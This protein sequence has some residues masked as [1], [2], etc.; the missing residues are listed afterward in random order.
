M[1]W[2]ASAVAL[3]VVAF[4]V[5]LAVQHRNEP[6]VPR[7]VQQHRVVPAFVV[8]NAAGGQIDSSTL[9]RK[10]YVVNFFNS[11]CIPCQQ[12]APALKAF[13]AE[14]RNDPDF[15]MIG[16]V[17]D[18]DDHAAVRSYVRREGITWPV[19]FD[20]TGSARL[21]FGTT[22]QPETYFVNSSG[23]AACGTLGASTLADL[24]SMLQAVRSGA[25]CS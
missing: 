16:V 23:V 14:H 1:R 24:E 17:R 9:A 3:V 4:G 21:G 13:Y 2:I 20:P 8:D 15:A 7:I 18:D 10:T 12:E 11:W 22:G 25:L 6:S 5:M 19:A